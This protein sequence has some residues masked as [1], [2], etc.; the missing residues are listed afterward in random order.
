MLYV[1]AF[2]GHLLYE[3]R[4]LSALLSWSTLTRLQHSGDIVKITGWCRVRSLYKF[5]LLNLAHPQILDCPE[6]GH[7]KAK[8]SITNGI[9]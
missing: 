7:P 6:Y 3:V 4:T 8:F 2:H 5:E 1:C 9:L